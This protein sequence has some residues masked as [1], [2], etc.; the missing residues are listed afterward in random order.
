MVGTDGRAV[1]LRDSRWASGLDM[2]PNPVVPDPPG[3]EQARTDG[4]VGVPIASG[5][6]KLPDERNGLVFVFRVFEKMSYAMVMRS[7]RPLYVG[8]IVQTP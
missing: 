3:L 1:S 2:R 7:S 6:L 4:K 5:P 8:D